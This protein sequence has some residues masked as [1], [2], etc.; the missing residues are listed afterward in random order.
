MSNCSL[1]SSDPAPTGRLHGPQRP[2]TADSLPAAV[3]AACMQPRVC[4]FSATLL[5]QHGSRPRWACVRR[6]W[7]VHGH[8]WPL[9]HLAS[10]TRPP[11]PSTCALR[12]PLPIQEPAP[13]SGFD[14]TVPRLHRS[15]E[16][17]RGCC[18][19]TTRADTQTHQSWSRGKVRAGWGRLSGPLGR[20]GGCPWSWRRGPP[21]GRRG[22]GG[23]VRHRRGPWDPGDRWGT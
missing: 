16:S 4:T 8:G 10:L 23:W 19:H 14:A 21:Q 7:H 3:P 9:S 2:W 22:S 20:E 6:D 15:A 1:A 5:G 12:L 13:Q 17:P 11:V 18:T